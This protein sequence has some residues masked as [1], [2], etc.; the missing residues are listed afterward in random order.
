MNH[1]SRLHDF[2]RAFTR[3]VDTAAQDEARILEY[4]KPLLADLIGHDDWLPA[5]CAR[6]HPDRYQQYLLH[7]DPQERFSVLSFVWGPGQATPVHDHTVWGMVGVLRGAE[8]CEEFAP[9]AGAGPL[10]RLGTHHLPAGAID[11]LS[12]RVGDIHR[13][14]NAQ[15][16]AVSV[17]IHVYGA[18]IGRI[19]RH[20]YDPATGA[21][22]RFVSGYSEVATP[23]A[24]QSLPGSGCCV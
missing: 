8:Q 2:V 12:P 10:A 16:G 17:S 7:C 24:G 15:A 22:S 23:E 11:V 6:P 5:A 4:G 20:V 13:V 3:L 1:P 21:A 18:D 9:P 19:A 14:A